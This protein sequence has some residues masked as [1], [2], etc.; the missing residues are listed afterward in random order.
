MT[1][2]RISRQVAMVVGLASLLSCSHL[3]SN[4]SD[5]EPTLAQARQATYRGLADVP[6]TVTLRD[7][8][9]EG[10]PYVVGGAS[11][12]R[13]VLAEPFHVMGDLDDDGH[14]ETVVL[15]SFSGGGSGEF[16]YFAVLDAKEGRVHNTATTPLGDRVKVVEAE[17]QGSTL[18]ARLLQAGPND[19]ACCPGDLITR[20]WRLDP[21]QGLQPVAIDA[22]T[23]RLTPDALSATTWRLRAWAFNEPVQ[24]EVVPTLQVEGDRI[25]G[26]GGCNRYFASVKG[27]KQPGD[28]EIGPVGATRMACPDP[29]MAIEDRFLAVLSKVTKFTF[30]GGQLALSYTDDQGAGTLL[31]ERTST[32]KE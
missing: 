19:A 2:G 18:R 31:F 13:V 25:G 17:V 20:A 21:E 32:E 5:T 10:E 6:E 28:L 26:F 29:G 27:G 7:G 15:L 4:A 30:L 22:D 11:R 3:P 14:D 12:P 9:W 16:V 24:G 1:S 23:Q 8:V